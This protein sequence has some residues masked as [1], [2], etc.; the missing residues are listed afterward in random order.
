MGPPRQTISAEGHEDEHI[1]AFDEWRGASGIF[2]I[3]NLQGEAAARVRE[4]QRRVDPRLANFAPPHITLIGSSGAGPIPAE[5]SV[6]RLREAL[7]PV[8]RAAAP[9][10]LF[11]GPPVRFIQT[12]IVGLPLDPH[13][14][15]RSLYEAIKRCGLA[16]ARSR[17]AFTP[18]VTL[19]LYRTLTKDDI[20]EL[21][22][23][24]VTEPVHIDHLQCS[25]TVEPNPPKALVT[26]AIGT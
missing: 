23:L 5:T 21:L 20:R 15:V 26:F 13:G 17:H 8:A 7:E 19:S 3:V 22:A 10:T 14:P 18:H 4:I 2:V 24:R 25:L 12:N 16:F 1:H 9:L 11:F 6:E